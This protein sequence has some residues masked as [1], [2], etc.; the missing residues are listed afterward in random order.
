MEGILV[1]DKPTGPTSADVVDLAKRALRT[2]VGHLGTLDPFASGVLPL[3]IG[4]ATKIARLLVVADKQYEGRIRLGVQ[5]DTGDPTGTVVA[6]QRVPADFAARLH[7]VKARLSGKRLQIPPMYSALKRGGVPLYKLARQGISVERE[8]RWIE[9]TFQYLEPEGKNVLRFQ[10]T[11]SKGTYI[12]V[13]AEEIGAALG[14]VAHLQ[15][16]RRTRFGPFTLKEAQP[17]SA[18]SESGIHKALIPL[19]RALGHLRQIALASQEVP[20]AT[21]GD[22]VL[23]RRLPPGSEGETALLVSDS[24]EAVALIEYRP[25]RGW[26]YLRVLHRHEGK[27]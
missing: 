12:R 4:D 22:L 25:D 9:L 18:L 24:G 26:V 17:L 2:K 15:E 21:R 8:P 3:C 13:L 16:L 11:C 20:R 23:L 1:V 6:E 19:V 5:T 7:E 14:T 10:V 27:S